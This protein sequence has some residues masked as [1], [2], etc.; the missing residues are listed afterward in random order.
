MGLPSH[1]ACD[2]DSPHGA[3]PGFAC[4]ALAEYV[5]SDHVEN[6]VDPRPM[7]EHVSHWRPEKSE[8]EAYAVDCKEK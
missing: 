3:F 1:A 7:Q 4:Y 6:E 2:K 5:E 8:G